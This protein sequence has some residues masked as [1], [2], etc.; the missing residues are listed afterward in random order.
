MNKKLIEIY[1]VHFSTSLVSAIW[2]NVCYFHFAKCSPLNRIRIL[3]KIMKYCKIF[4][5][6]LKR[7]HKFSSM[8]FCYTSYLY[9]ILYISLWLWFI[10]DASVHTP[11]S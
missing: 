2:P 5:L 11:L 3:N 8:K 10:G 9:I 1:I 7:N 6:P 4:V